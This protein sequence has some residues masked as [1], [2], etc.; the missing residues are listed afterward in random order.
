M[1]I[2]SRAGATAPVKVESSLDKLREMHKEL[3][4]TTRRT[5]FMML[6][7]GTSCGLIIVQ[8][9]IPLVLLS[10]GVQLPVINVSVNLNAF[11]LVGPIGLVVITT[12]LHIFLGKIERITGLDEYDKQPFLFNF[13]DWFS[14]FLGFLIFYTAPS[15]VMAGFSWK[16]SV[17]VLSRPMHLA[18]IVVTAGVLSLYL[19]RR[20]KVRRF[21]F[22]SISIVLLVGIPL[23]WIGVGS[24]I[25][26]RT[27]NLERAKLLEAKL[28]I[29]DLSSANLKFSN[30]E[31]ADLWM[32]NLQKA[33]LQGAN[34]YNANLRKAGLQL[35]NLSEA[36]LQGANLQGARLL[37]LK[38]FTID[39]LCTTKTLYKAKLDLELEQQIGEKCP[40][41]RTEE[42]SKIF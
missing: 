10:S 24:P 4:I 32:A 23:L 38:N 9:D 20:L 13:Q 11:L 18:T 5:M 17:T 30:L 21:I 29:T 7:Y 27:L 12:Y 28:Q 1:G 26:K 39:Q 3:S 33:N 42:S 16:S 2:K 41:L 19:K 6:A 37:K 22:V 34:L 36:N 40:Y 8:P 25:Y 15:I 14:R 35:A 31:L